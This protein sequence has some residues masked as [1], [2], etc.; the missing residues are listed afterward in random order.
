MPNWVKNEIETTEDV[1]ELLINDSGHVDFTRVVE[2]KMPHPDL[3][4][5]VPFSINFNFILRKTILRIE[6][7]AKQDIT[8]E[9]YLALPPDKKLAAAID[10][11]AKSEGLIQ[12][13]FDESKK[14]LLLKYA[15][16]VLACG[17]SNWYDAQLAYWGTKWNACETSIEEDGKIRFDTAWSC[18]HPIYQA[19]QKKFPNLN[20]KAKWADEDVGYNCGFLEIK[21]GKL[22]TF[23]RSNH[24]DDKYLNK[25]WFLYAIKLWRS[26][27]EEY[28]DIS[29][30]IDLANEEI[31]GYTGLMT[32]ETPIEKQ[33]KQEAE[34]EI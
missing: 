5:P 19:L 24:T 7:G 23:R 6:N 32:I 1:R 4:F 26:N 15:E 11:M 18:P 27:I 29:N 22:I 20:L 33:M 10:I 31:E 16:N 8:L 30:F 3:Q 25:A 2:I 34:M 17:F 28:I 13:E 12:T 14:E 9:E 21:D